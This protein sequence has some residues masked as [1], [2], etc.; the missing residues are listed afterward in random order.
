MNARSNRHWLAINVVA[1]AL[2]WSTDAATNSFSFIILGDLHYDR[3]AHHDMA[4]LA[5]D[6]PNDVHQVENYSRITAEVT[7]KLFATLRETIA[8]LNKNPETHV[9]F[10]AQLGDFVEGLCGSPKLARQ[11]CDDA[12]AFVT[13]AK[14]GAPFLITKGNHDVTGPGA[15]EAYERVLLPFI[16]EQLGEPV[17]AARFVVQRDDSLFLFFD[18][19]DRDASL[20]WLEE[21]LA[22]HPTKHAFVLLHPPLVPFTAR[23]QWTL[24]KLEEEKQR[25][26]LFATL[27]DRQA[28]VLSAHLHK[29]GAVTRTAGRNRF[30]QLSISS[31]ISA[32]DQKPKDV[33]SGS[34]SYGPDLTNLEPA[35]DP[36]S[37][38]WRRSMLVREKPSI[39]RFE[40]ADAPGYAVVTV[41]S[42]N[43]IIRAYAGTAREPW[44]TLD[45]R[46]LLSP[47]KSREHVP[48]LHR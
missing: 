45:V 21:T 15:A 6:H 10:V 43:A 20:K 4:W 46:D 32:T 26:A 16:G 44:K 2:A 31:V 9:A 40:Y 28:V 33:L 24:F 23:S 30:V 38:V 5:K 11:Q 14:L 13:D 22:K 48:P 1:I 8:D 42:T 29:F 17:K 37:V 39:L 25:N 47:P 7:P 27:A 36:A 41:N 35:F 19:Y 3:L 12:V 18:A 34:D